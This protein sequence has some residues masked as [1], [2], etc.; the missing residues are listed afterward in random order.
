ME[1][2]RNNVCK[3]K[4]KAGTKAMLRVLNKDG[5]ALYATMSVCNKWK[6][7]SVTAPPTGDHAFHSVFGLK[8]H[9]I[10]F[11]SINEGNCSIANGSKQCILRC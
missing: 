5:L 2:E 10:I 4:H 1:G 6:S 7:W 3:H 8:D 11:F 9:I